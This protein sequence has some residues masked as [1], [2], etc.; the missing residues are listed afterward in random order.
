MQPDARCGTVRP[1]VVPEIVTLP[2][3]IDLSN[4]ARVGN[5]L[6]AALRPGVAVVI[7]DMSQTRFCDSSGIRHLLIAHE[8][9]TANRVELRLAVSAPAVIRTMRVTGV[10]KVFNIYPSLQEALAT[11]RAELPKPGSSST[12]SAPDP[13]EF[14]A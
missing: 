8:L 9:A 4:A 3:E 6:R 5:D 11:R 10:D 14:P 12:V 1:L 13:S 7:A 2:A